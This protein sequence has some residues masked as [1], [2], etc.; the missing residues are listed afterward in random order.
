MPPESPQAPEPLPLEP[1]ATVAAPFERRAF[2]GAYQPTTVIKC[3]K[4]DT[5]FEGV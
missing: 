2:F 1:G 5:V 4:F 3:T